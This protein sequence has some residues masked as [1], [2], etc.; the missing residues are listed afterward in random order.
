RGAGV[1][2]GHLSLSRGSPGS[3]ASVE[4]RIRAFAAMGFAVQKFSFRSR[5]K[6]VADSLL[7]G[8]GA[9]WLASSSSWAARFL[10]AR[11]AEVGRP[12]PRPAHR[13]D[14]GHWSDNALTLAW[15]GHASVLINFYGVRILT[16]PA[17]FDRIG[18]ATWLG[19]IGPKRLL[20]CA[21]RPQELPE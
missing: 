9:G 2:R 18:A 13:P 6:F 11:L 19:T 21:L 4:L 17:F 14:P 3:G 10:R 5:R 20:G 16:D 8:L 1:S 15:L 12:V 7:A